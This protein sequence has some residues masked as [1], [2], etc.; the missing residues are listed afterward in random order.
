MQK[1]LDDNDVLIISSAD[2]EGKSIVAER[3]IRT[4]KANIYKEMTANNSDCYLDYL[5]KL[6]DEYNNSYHCCIGKKP[7]DATVF[8]FECKN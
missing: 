7:V 3:F 5:N 2:N 6:V 1:L 4:L 8:F